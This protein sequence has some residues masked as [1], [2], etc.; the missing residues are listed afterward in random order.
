MP[1]KLPFNKYYKQ[2]KHHTIKF[3]KS[4]KNFQSH[5][6]ESNHNIYTQKASYYWY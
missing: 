3:H 6:L 4:W 2:N 5:S 1:Q